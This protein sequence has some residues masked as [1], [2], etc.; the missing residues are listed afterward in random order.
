MIDYII[1][2]RIFGISLFVYNVGIILILPY[3]FLLTVLFLRQIRKSKFVI[4]I[5]Y[6]ITMIALNLGSFLLT[7][8]FYFNNVINF[9]DF[10]KRLN[11]NEWVYNDLVFFSIY[12]CIAFVLNLISMVIVIIFCKKKGRKTSVVSYIFQLILL[13]LLLSEFSIST[14]FYCQGI[15]KVRINEICSSNYQQYITYYNDVLYDDC[16]YI[17]IKNDGILP[18]ELD[19]YYLSDK[20]KNLLKYYVPDSTLLPGEYLVVPLDSKF[21]EEGMFGIQKFLDMP[22]VFSR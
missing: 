4:K 7:Y 6:V 21:E 19:A 15:K 17:E 1:S 14:S 18:V 12:T 16:D 11:R 20:Q 2:K 3:I 10:I 8:Y 5:T 13:L 9:I 22:Y